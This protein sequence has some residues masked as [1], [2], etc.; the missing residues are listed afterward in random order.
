M[1]VITKALN[2]DDAVNTAIKN[3]VDYLWLQQMCPN[4]EM[5]FHFKQ[6]S[7]H[8][9]QAWCFDCLEANAAYT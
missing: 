1:S 3:N 9:E 4:C 8:Q 2:Y 5:I 6:M 7:G